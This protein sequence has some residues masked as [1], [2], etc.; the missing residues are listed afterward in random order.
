[1]ERASRRIVAWVLGCQGA[2]PAR[3]LWAAL[4][5]RSQRHC[6]YYTDQWKAYAKGVVC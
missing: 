5:R 6:H 1:M 4:P 2:A 3:R